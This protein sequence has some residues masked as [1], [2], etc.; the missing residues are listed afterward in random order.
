MRNS[1]E[2]YLPSTPPPSFE[3]KIMRA[4]WGELVYSLSISRA[5]S[6]SLPGLVGRELLCGEAKSEREREYVD[7]WGPDDR[8]GTEIRWYGQC[9]ARRN[10]MGKRERKSVSVRLAC[11]QRGLL[12]QAARVS[13]LTV[14]L[15]SVVFLL[16]LRV[17]RSLISSLSVSPSARQEI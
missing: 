7:W 2:P 4:W 3:C 10:S 8:R 5:L 1:N 9:R 17:W 11:G 16:A 15:L 6:L 14:S 13:K 12:E